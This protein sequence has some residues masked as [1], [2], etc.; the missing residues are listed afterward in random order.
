MLQ[1]K[2]ISKSYDDFQAV[3]NLNIEIKDGE[4]WTL[5]GRN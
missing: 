1:I 2:N 3:K 5:L 4:C